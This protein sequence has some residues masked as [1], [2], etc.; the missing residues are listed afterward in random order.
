MTGIK[1]WMNLTVLNVWKEN[2]CYA[3]N[4]VIFMPKIDSF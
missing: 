1:K 4:G 3:Q 2:P